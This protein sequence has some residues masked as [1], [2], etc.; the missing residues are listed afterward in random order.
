MVR[1]PV[2][3]SMIAAVSYDADA[4]VLEVEMNHGGAYAYFDVPQELFDSFLNAES[5]GRFWQ[6]ALQG[7]YGEMR[8]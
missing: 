5:M 3:S 7:R 1:V 6:S 8:V 2:A 4:G